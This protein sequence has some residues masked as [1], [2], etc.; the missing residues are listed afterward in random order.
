MYT[1]IFIYIYI[2]TYK[3]VL[4]T[5]VE[6]TRIY[7]IVTQCVYIY[8]YSM[9]SPA[10]ARIRR[11]PRETR[12]AAGNRGGVRKRGQNASTFSGMLEE[13]EEEEEGE[14]VGREKREGEQEEEEVVTIAAVPGVCGQ[15]RLMMTWLPN[16][17]VC[18]CV[19]VCMC[20][21]VGVC[22]CV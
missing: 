6:Y 21:C 12:A 11:R 5:Y 8:I 14:S 2:Y 3:Y 15:G 20:V 17:C 19:C 16:V 10:L 13:E 9:C 4:Y 7:R 18:S 22:V 1:Y